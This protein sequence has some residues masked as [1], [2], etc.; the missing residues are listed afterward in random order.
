MR[1]EDLEKLDSA[2]LQRLIS[3]AASVLAARAGGKSEASASATPGSIFTFGATGNQLPASTAPSYGL[4]G[5]S[6]KLFSGTGAGL[7]G[8]AV[9]GPG[10]SKA[11][12]T[13]AF[14]PAPRSTAD[15]ANRGAED[16]GDDG[17]DDG[18]QGELVKEEEIVKVDGWE[19][20]ITLQ[21]LDGHETG[22]ENEEEIY[23]QR[24]KL[25]RYREGEWK[26]RGLG[27]A[28][29]LRSKTTGRVRFLLRQEKTGKVVANHFVV[30]HKPYCDLRKNADS[31]KIWV[32]CAQ[33]FSDG[34]AKI[35]E[36]ALKF[37]TSNLAGKFRDAFEDAKRQNAEA[38][39]DTT[40]ESAKETPAD[41][42]V[43][44]AAA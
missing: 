35:E 28:R 7:F 10:V 29:L 5:S 12:G 13:L 16:E 23:S 11:N 32:W 9:A 4:F 27:E 1:V 15:G 36:L 14:D 26:E 34:E 19:P 24:S 39:A 37:G 40:K 8:G 20:S 30:D 22:E 43:A 17:D 38:E 41:P 6:G 18:E 33:D 31:D 42:E 3:D 21:V 25:Y 2:E 44:K